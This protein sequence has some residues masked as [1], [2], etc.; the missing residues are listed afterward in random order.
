[1]AVVCL[2]KSFILVNHGNHR[3][4]K[5]GEQVNK[6]SGKVY[7]TYEGLDVSDIY[8]RLLFLD[9]FDLFKI[10]AYTICSNNHTKV[11]NL[12]HMELGFIDIGL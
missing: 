5:F 4:Y 11:D 10:Y 2:G 8:G 7:E 3:G 1:M 9:Y 6:L 12:G